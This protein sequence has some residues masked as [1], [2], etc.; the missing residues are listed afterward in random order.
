MIPMVRQYWGLRE[1][2][3]PLQ[4]ALRTAE[5]NAFPSGDM[6]QNP[7]LKLNVDLRADLFRDTPKGT[8]IQLRGTVIR[9]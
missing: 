3:A 1:L 7:P 4:N 2:H 9:M 8:G 5:G 6:A